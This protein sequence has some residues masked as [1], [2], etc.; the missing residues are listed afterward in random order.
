[1]A[2]KR[3][4]LVTAVVFSTATATAALAGCSNDGDIKAKSASEER[5]EQQKQER[6]Q[7]PAAVTSAAPT[8]LTGLTA[9]QIAERAVAATQAARSMRMAG[10]VTSEGERASVD[11]AVDNKGACTGKLG[12]GGGSAE[13][14]QVSKVLYMKGNEKFWRA[15]LS[16][17][18]SPGTD[19]EG[20][21]ELVKDR[22][23]KMPAGSA[24]AMGGVCDLKA[25]L[26]ERD[27][28]TS[29]RQG[30]TKGPDAEVNSVPTT[31]L[32]KKQPGGETITMY[33]AKKGEPYLIRVVRVGGDGPGTM[34]FSDYNKPVK[35]VAP[36]ADQVVDLEKLGTGLSAGPGSGS[37]TGSRFG[38][39]FGFGFGFGSG[40]GT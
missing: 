37:G 35:A 18:S 7:E 4:S 28:D 31:T 32:V 15:S 33:V 3:K 10:Q 16:E 22:W 38:L 40:T 23:I 24:K 20:V 12:F 26:A 9:D 13:L 2:A 14:R 36:P 30:M 1:M 11:L 27:K 6:E 19:G 17:S 29:E 21:V 25:M 8:D 5:R 34:T 39:G